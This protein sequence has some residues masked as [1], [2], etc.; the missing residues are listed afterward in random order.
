MTLKREYDRATFDGEPTDFRTAVLARLNDKELR[1]RGFPPMHCF[2]GSYSTDVGASGTTHAGGG[3]LD[4]GWP[5]ASIAKHDE[6]MCFLRRRGWTGGWCRHPNTGFILHLHIIDIGN[7][8]LSNDAQLQLGNLRNNGDGLWPLVEGD[9]P[10][11]CR[12]DRYRG[13]DFDA[14]RRRALEAAE[15]RRDLA[16]GRVAIRELRRQIARK[17]ERQ[18]TRRDRLA[19]LQHHR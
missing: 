15:L 10:M 16:D 14:W 7:A 13:W 4:I 1:Q 9:D 11:K 2:Q 3:V 18:E 12:P 19:K 17:L 8:R 5:G 6:G